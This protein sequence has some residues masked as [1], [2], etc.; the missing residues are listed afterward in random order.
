MKLEGAKSFWAGH[1]EKDV[2][3]ANAYCLSND[4]ELKQKW[5]K[6]TVSYYRLFNDGD[7][8]H[9]GRL[10]SLAKFVGFEFPRFTHYSEAYP[11][12]EIGN[13]LLDLVLQD[14]AETVNYD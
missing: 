3:V 13:R 6:F 7:T 4:T 11:I 14:R 10:K 5:N 9:F 12:E 2:S 1:R 8:F